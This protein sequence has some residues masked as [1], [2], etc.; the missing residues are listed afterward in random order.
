MVV[1]T[2]TFERAAL[3]EV[4]VNSRSSESMF[5]ELESFTA[6]RVL[7]DTASYMQLLTI[8]VDLLLGRGKIC[9]CGSRISDARNILAMLLS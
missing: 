5:A 6:S 3:N 4:S 8:T 2:S 1:Q 9:D 7:S